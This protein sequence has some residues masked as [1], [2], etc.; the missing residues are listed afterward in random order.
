MVVLY[1]LCTQSASLS[2]LV[3]ALYAMRSLLSDFGGW[4]PS[5]VRS[6]KSILEVDQGRK[7]DNS[8]NGGGADF[9]H[10]ARGIGE[11]NRAR[12]EIKAERGGL[13]GSAILEQLTAE[14]GGL[15]HLWIGRPVVV[16]VVCLA[17]LQ[18][19]WFLDVLFIF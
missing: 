13:L 1:G 4:G 2:Y 11:A 8:T 12:E 9:W 19:L 3:Q 5:Y 17:W 18:S 14:T 16:V 10:L 7:G 6:A 15:V